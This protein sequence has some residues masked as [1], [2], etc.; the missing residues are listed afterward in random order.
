MPGVNSESEV[1]GNEDGEFATTITIVM[2]STCNPK[3]RCDAGRMQDQDDDGESEVD[4]TSEFTIVI[5]INVQ[6]TC[7]EK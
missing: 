7:N 3:C 2:Q 6:S 5:A 4:G 1:D